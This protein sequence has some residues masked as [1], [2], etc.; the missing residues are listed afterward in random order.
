VILLLAA[1]LP[2]LLWEGEPSTAPQLREAGIFQILVPAWRL[3]EWA[4]VGDF[5]VKA[6]D[7]TGA[8]KLSAP[9]VDRKVQAGATGE[10]WLVSNGWRFLRDPRE[11]F[12]YDVPGTRAALAAA[13]AFLFGAPATIRTDEAGLKPLG[14]MLRFLRSIPASDL[15]PVSDIGFVDDGSPAAGEVMNLM[16]RGNLLFDV[17]PSADR[18]HKVTVRQGSPEYPAA[19]WKNPSVMAHQ[20]RANL[21]DDRRSVRLYGSP[22]VVSRLYRSP[23]AVRIVLLNYAA[24]ERKVEGVRVRVLGKYTRAAP[25]APSEQLADFAAGEDATE[26]TLTE[27]N[28][29]AV[30]DLVR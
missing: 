10:P 8:T 20:I 15:P 4:P 30:I 25:G 28:S 27:L 19:D 16:V 21:T 2:S 14:A 22:V 5:S 6:G 11:R 7:V 17:L 13:E 23:D 12:Y 9:S 18:S 24:A 26:F 1:A 3:K 29:I